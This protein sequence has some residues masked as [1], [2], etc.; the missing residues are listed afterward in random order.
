MT[1]Q[2]KAFKN[3][4]KDKLMDF[5]YGYIGLDEIINYINKI[6]DEKIQDNKKSPQGPNRCKCSI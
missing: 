1:K 5:K 3:D 6:K 2:R 4:L